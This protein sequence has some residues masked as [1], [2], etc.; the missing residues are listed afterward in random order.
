MRCKFLAIS[1]SL[2]LLAAPARTADE[3][4]APRNKIEVPVAIGQTVRGIR[5]PH[6]ER[7]SN[8]LNL[9][10]NAESAERASETKFTFKGLRIEIFDESEEKPAMEVILPEAV[11]DRETNLLTGQA[12]SVIRGE[13]F[14]ITGRQLEFDSN[15]RD[16]RLL[17]PV[18]MILTQAE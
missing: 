9:R 11:Y 6:Y 13:Q 5:L 2:A 3:A 8:K 14:E 18:V 1:A 17:G 10:L 7:G 12:D 15:T 16:S 4:E